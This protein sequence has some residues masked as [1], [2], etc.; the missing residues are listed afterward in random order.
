MKSYITITLLLVSLVYGD[1]KNIDIIEHSREGDEIIAKVEMNVVKFEKEHS[2]AYGRI[3]NA[4][5]KEYPCLRIL[6]P[7]WFLVQNRDISEDEY[8]SYYAERDFGFADESYERF[9]KYLKLYTK[10]KFKGSSLARKTG[11]I[12]LQGV[13]YFKVKGK[14]YCFVGY[15]YMKGSETSRFGRF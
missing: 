4:L 6:Q 15:T 8:F 9:K 13:S 2:M 5:L 1:F 11:H 10:E 12:Y 3:D 7:E 14:T